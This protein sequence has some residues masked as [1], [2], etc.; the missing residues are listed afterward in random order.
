MN[1]KDFN[2]RLKRAKIVAAIMIPLLVGLLGL[3]LFGS[4]LRKIYDHVDYQHVSQKEAHLESEDILMHLKLSGEGDFW[5]VENYNIIKTHSSIFFG[6]AR[7]TYLGNESEIDHSN[8]FKYEFKLS[9]HGV[10]RVD[11]YSFKGTVA[12]L[13][14]AKYLG[15][16]IEP[17]TQEL[18]KMTTEDF[19]DSTL[20]LE[21]NNNKGERVYETIHLDGCEIVTS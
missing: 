10:L 13:Q 11:S 2:M 19:T 4:D 15:S 16:S 20:E 17:L 7:L 6:D 8:Y 14:N 12:I 18:K 21:W 3:I 5:K 9:E 1:V